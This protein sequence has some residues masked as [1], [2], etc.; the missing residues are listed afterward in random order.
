[1]KQLQLITLA[2][3][4]SFVSCKKENELGS[5]SG[6]VV[7]KWKIERK[8]EIWGVN[9]TPEN[10][11][12]D[13]DWVEFKA[14]GEYIESFGEGWGGYQIAG[15]WKILENGNLELTASRDIP[16]GD[17]GVIIKSISDKA[18][19]LYYKGLFGSYYTEATY[20]LYLVRL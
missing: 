13:C 12:V 18:M 8:E 14:N 3:F 20:N 19:H 9:G 11:V 10:K 2:L 16:H 1:M 6:D 15:K 7:G 4:F 17:D 5:K